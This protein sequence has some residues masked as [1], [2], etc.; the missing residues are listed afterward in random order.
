[1]LK[2]ITNNPYRV[3]GVLSNTPLR[4]R[5]GNQNRLTAFAKI[6]KY[7]SFPNDFMLVIREKPLR[8]AENISAAN[9]A[10][11]CDKDKL[12]NALFWFINNSSIDDIAIKHLHSGNREKA[13]ELFEKKETF[14]S[15]LNVGVLQML[16]GD[17]TS[18][19]ANIS[20]IIHD[21]NLRTVLLTALGLQNLTI[22]EDEIA[23]MCIE[24][25]LKE[26]PATTLISTVSNPMDKSIIIKI[27]LEEPISTINSAIAVA[28]SVD[29]RNSKASL[30]AGNKL[31]NSTKKALKQV[32][33]IAGTSNP[34]YQV[35]A[36]NLAKQILQCGINY[37]NNE[38]D[39]DIEA[40]RKAEVLQGYALKIAVGKLT[41]DRCQENYDII[42]RAVDNIPPAEVASDFIRIR[43]LTNKFADENKK[44]LFQYQMNQMC[45]DGEHFKSELAFEIFEE[46][47]LLFGKINSITQSEH[48]AFLNLCDITVSQWLKTIIEVTNR[49]ISQIESIENI[50]IS[51]MSLS[52]FGRHHVTMKMNLESIS[53]VV[54]NLGTIPMSSEV[55]EWYERQQGLL[56][57]LR[58]SYN[59]SSYRKHYYKLQSENEVYDECNSISDYKKY[60]KIYPEGIYSAD[61][62]KRIIEF[63]KEKRLKEQKKIKEEQEEL[64]LLEEISTAS[65]ILN[66]KSK[67]LR[68][69]SEKTRNAWDDKFFNLCESRK[70]YQNYLRSIKKPRHY[71]VAKK[72]AEINCMPYA[73][74]LCVICIIIGIAIKV[75]GLSVLIGIVIII[76]GG[77]IED[78]I[79]AE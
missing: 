50:C 7:V 75:T 69:Q 64:D 77:L 42:K 5:V 1:M 63:E 14:S 29:A 11:N 71:T 20:K 61:A 27:A 59:I 56:G 35:V 37:Y 70:D 58:S 66:L 2:A 53:D 73:I 8:T 54:D 79:N 28:K 78:F 13:L 15:L 40:P 39:D 47:I 41:K 9:T 60:L 72:N 31:M 38:S 55:R 45:G 22:T 30:V 46:I 52:R 48:P 19:F 62:K 36:D 43:N 68:C 26:V 10:L 76:L 67:F 24:E 74:S 16:E 65:T 51:E 17:Y 57:E 23:S 3:L 25:M 33:D 34:Q 49:Y 32:R 18:G 12:K 6:G 4:E 44:N 21:Q